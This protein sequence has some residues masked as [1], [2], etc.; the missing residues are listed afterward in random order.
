[1]GVRGMSSTFDEIIEVLSRPSERDKQRRIGPSELG[2]LCERCLAEKMLGTHED[3]DR[4]TPFAPMLG[5]A[6]YVSQ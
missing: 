6:L 2:D 3:D 4:G 1:M 5:T